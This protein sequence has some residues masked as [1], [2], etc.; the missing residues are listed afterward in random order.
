[1]GADNNGTGR[2]LSGGLDELFI[3]DYDIGQAGVD[4]LYQAGLN[5]FYPAAALDLSDT[6][7]LVEGESTLTINTEADVLFGDLSVLLLDGGIPLTLE[8]DASD[9]YF[10]SIDILDPSDI[11][12]PGQVYDLIALTDAQGSPRTGIL[13]G[14]MFGEALFNGQ[15]LSML[16]GGIFYS[17]DGSLV[18]FRAYIPEPGTMALLGLGLLGLARR[19]RRRTSR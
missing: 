11:R 4:Y 13:G 12:I 10:D 2:E 5:G 17:N 15:P 7:L 8:T 3:Y 6:D 1:M 16:D 18:Q 14:D 19:R 9:V